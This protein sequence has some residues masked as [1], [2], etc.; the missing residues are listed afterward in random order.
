[1]TLLCWCL[2]LMIC[3]LG[4]KQ[5]ALVAA[6]GDLITLGLDVVVLKGMETLLWMLHGEMLLMFA[7]W[8]FCVSLPDS[9]HLDGT[10]SLSLLMHSINLQSRKADLRM[11]CLKRLCVSLI[12]F[13]VY[14]FHKCGTHSEGTNPHPPATRPTTTNPTPQQSVLRREKLHYSSI[15]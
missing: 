7:D 8:L 1:M 11:F 15:S 6:L 10:H 12:C 9:S 14:R 5:E 2:K 3:L 4:S 13:I